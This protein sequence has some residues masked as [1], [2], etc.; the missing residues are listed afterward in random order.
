MPGWYIH[1]DVARKALAHLS[2]NTGAASIFSS[3]GPTAAEVTQIAKNNPAYVALGS[4]GPDFFFLLPD[5]KPPMGSGI[6][7]VANTIREIYTWWD[8]NFLGPWEDQMGPIQDN[9]SDEVDALTGGLASQLSSILSR[10]FSFLLDSVVVMMVRQYDVFG[11][12]GSGIISAYDEQVFF[13]SDMMHYRKTSEFAAYL[14]KKANDSGDDRFK[15]FAL[16]WMSHLSA[17]VTGHCFVNEKVGGPYRLHWQRHHLVENHM[18]GKVCDVDSGAKP[19]YNMLSNSALHLWLA[20]SPDG[21]SH[22]NFFNAQPGPA[23]PTGDKT[24]DLLARHAA[25]DVDSDL[26]EDMGDFIAEALKEFYSSGITDSNGSKGQCA[27][28]PTIWDSIV[29][30]TKGF[31]SG[32]DVVNTYWWVFHYL[33]YITT[34]YYKIRRPE[35]PDVF[36]VQPFPSPP[37]SG[38]SDPGPGSSD[39]SAW[40]DFLEILLAI[41]AWIIYLAQVAAW[42]V[43]AI[44]GLITSAGTYPIRELLYE[45]LELPLYNAWLA[46]HWYLCMSGFS[47]PMQQEIN[48]GLNTLGIGVGNV[49]GSVQDALNDL[50]GGLNFPPNSTENSGWDVNKMFPFDVVNDPQGYI[51]SLIHQILN[52]TCGAAEAPSEFLRPWLWPAKDNEGD[53]VPSELKRT[54]GSPYAKLKDCMV[55]MGGLSGDAGTRSAYENAGNESATMATSDSRIPAGKTLGDA[56]DFTGY[57]VAKLTRDNP[58]IKGNFN[59][60]SDRGYG[61]LCWDWQRSKDLMGVPDAFKTAADKRSYHLPI[62]PG[63]GWCKNEATGGIPQG[64]AGHET[65]V[66][67]RY[68]DK[69]DKYI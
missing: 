23:Y 26:P 29:P 62:H 21:S 67:I 35:A 65:G 7:G 57:M 10:A 44:I 17:D 19:I 28:H 14:W 6:Y 36:N 13:W 48:P 45:N 41:F 22:N 69:E 55:F 5:F 32:T 68:I 33:K 52:N 47:Y 61:Y 3:G 40:H 53:N 56:I 34:D 42:P 60:D 31:I 20:F 30:G 39:D 25:W 27:P 64:P 49:W 1:M 18:D 46:L 59:M 38:E 2:S 24:P 50:D 11:F 8:D 54:K 58:E 16:G 12:L 63:T 9:L 37:G 66:K 4:I 43:T 15:A 51:S